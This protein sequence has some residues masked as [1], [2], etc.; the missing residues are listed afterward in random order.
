MQFLNKIKYLYSS[1]GLRTVSLINKK[2]NGF[3][4]L[5]L[6]IAMVIVSISFMAILPL[7]WNTISVN[8]TMSIGAVAKDV[9][10]Q[11]VEELMSLP[12]DTFDS[13]YGLAIN[14]SYT[15][16]IEYVTKKG[17][18]TADTTALFQR[19]FSI[20]QVTG[21]TVNPKP[22]ILTSVVQYTYKGEIRTRSFSTMWSF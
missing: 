5:E 3:T 12:R 11:K 7:L 1:S 18:V 8:K 17:E 2:R 21:A 4:L 16:P 10:V 6:L 20:N 9:A 22:V 14:N 19:T 15:S 13:T